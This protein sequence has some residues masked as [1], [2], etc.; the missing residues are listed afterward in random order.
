MPENRAVRRQSAAKYPS[1]DAWDHQRLLKGL[2]LPEVAGQ[3]SMMVDYEVPDMWALGSD[4]E[5]PNPLASMALRLEQGVTNTDEFTDEENT[6]YYELAC[7]VIATHLRKPN[8]VEICGSVEAAVESVKTKLHPDRRDALWAKS[9]HV[10]QPADFEEVL[11]S[12]TALEKSRDGNDGTT[13]VEPG[14]QAV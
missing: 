7:R 6:T 10:F 8:L 3:P 2:T 1:P 13:A 14:A 9:I 4:G 11:R 5:L 12:I